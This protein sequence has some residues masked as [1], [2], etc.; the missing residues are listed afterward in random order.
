MAKNKKPRKAYKPKP[1]IA[2]PVEHALTSVKLIKCDID[3]AQNLVLPAYSS[4]VDLKEG[5]GTEL[6]L[7]NLAYVYNRV[8]ALWRLGFGKEHEKIMKSAKEAIL[9]CSLRAVVVGGYRPTKQEI[10]AFEGLLDLH[11]ALIEVVTVAD[12]RKANQLI[13]RIVSSG[14]ATHVPSLK[15]KELELATV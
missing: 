9:S 11:D 3:K 14:G 15:A 6:H 10:E 4:L 12:L 8:E 13:D 1:V 5:N 7:N 2:N